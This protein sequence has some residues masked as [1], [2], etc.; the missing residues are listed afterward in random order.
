MQNNF[1]WE[2]KTISCAIVGFIAN[3]SKKNKILNLKIISIL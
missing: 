2:L 3:K 1:G